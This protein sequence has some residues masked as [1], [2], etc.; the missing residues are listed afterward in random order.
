VVAAVWLATASAATADA[1]GTTV[2]VRVEIA[3]APVTAA[4]IQPMRFGTVLPGDAPDVPPGAA[5]PSAP[6]ASAG[7]MLNGIR[8]GRDIELT[9]TLP[10]ELV[11]GAYSIPVDW[12][13]AGYGTLCVSRGGPCLISAMFNPAVGPVPL[14]IPINAAGNNFDV[15]VYAGAR[16]SIPPVPPGTYAASV[17][18]TM[19][20]VN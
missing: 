15:T 3:P 10:P 5:P 14:F 2:Q 18:L 16:A 11:L 19:A 4:G 9:L 17:T 20:Y 12:D 8:K 1:Q 6:T 13:N 7:W